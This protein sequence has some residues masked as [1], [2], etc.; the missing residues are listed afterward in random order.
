M[1]TKQLFALMGVIVTGVFLSACGRSQNDQQASTQT[2][3]S[4][5]SDQMATLD[6]AKYSDMISLEAMDNA[7]E[8]LY[9]FDQK[10]KPVLAG[11]QSV[12]SNEEHTIYTFKLRKKA[13]WSNGDPVKASDYVYA[14]QNIISPST[15]SPNSQRLDPIKNAQAIRKGELSP[16]QLGV[17]ALDDQT[18][19]VQLEA[20]IS[21]LDELLTGAPFFPK[22]QKVAEKFDS[23]YGTT[24]KNAVYNGPFVVSGWQGTN[25]QWNYVKNK[26]YWDQK[27]VKLAKAEIQVVKDTSTAG[28]LYQTGKLDYTILGNE[29]AKQYANDPGYHT[30]KIPLIGYLGFNTKR[31]ITGNVHARKAIAQGFDKQLLVKN[32][33]NV[34]TPLNGIVPADFAYNSATDKEYRKQAGDLLPYDKKKAQAEWALAKQE[35]GQDEL[36]LEVLSSDTNEAK[37]VAT[38]LQSQLEENLPGLKVNLRSIPLKSRLAA[39]TAYNYDVVYGTWQPDYADPVNFISDG[40]QY[41]LNTDYTNQAFWNDLDQAATT[42]ANDPAKR[43][44]TLID[45]ETKLIKDD[46]YTAPV[47]QGAMTYLLSSKVKGLSISPYGTVLLYRDVEVE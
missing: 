38:Y 27:A 30:K 5:V 2:I 28:K 6:T 29:F 43:W 41:H 39:T 13:K 33:L 32:V 24:S 7:F 10:G 44:E 31:D 17:K 15:A 35:L 4:A 46:T 47:Y 40:G 3:R 8:G 12:T 14:W 42:Y 21:Y 1:K 37:Q 26:Q 34:G 9:R 18:L 36:T 25:D 16:T 19:Q 45:A 22:N 20:P 11:A 23:K